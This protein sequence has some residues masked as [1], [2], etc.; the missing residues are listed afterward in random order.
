MI[1]CDKNIMKMMIEIKKL[2]AIILIIYIVS[3]TYLMIFEN[4]LDKYHY[5]YILYL[6][7]PFFLILAYKLVK[8]KKL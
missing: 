6:F 3:V 8:K 4:F 5:F 2:I 7:V 1:F